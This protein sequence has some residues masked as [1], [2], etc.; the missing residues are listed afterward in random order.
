MSKMRGL[1]ALGA[2]VLVFVL[3]AH[4]QQ[5]AAP[6]VELFQRAPSADQ[7]MRQRIMTDRL[8]LAMDEHRYAQMIAGERA[9]RQAQLTSYKDG[10]NCNCPATGCD[11][12]KHQG[13]ICKCPGDKKGGMPPPFAPFN[14]DSSARKSRVGAL[15]QARG[16]Y[17]PFTQGPARTQ[18]KWVGGAPAYL[19]P[20]GDYP[21]GSTGIQQ[22]GYIAY[23]TGWANDGPFH[24]ELAPLQEAGIAKSPVAQTL[25]QAS[26]LLLSPCTWVTRRTCQ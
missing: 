23:E 20:D 12:E 9:A 15:R 18:Q 24:G 8:H 11:E 25:R 3:V 17:P 4:H 21:G 26:V 5:A 14:F 16:A 19:P 6:A 1:M 10:C 22:D 7:V 13:P 2:S